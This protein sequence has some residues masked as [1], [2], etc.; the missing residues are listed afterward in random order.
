[1]E[2]NAQILANL[3]FLCLNMRL[4]VNCAKL[5]LQ[6]YHFKYHLFYPM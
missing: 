3:H 1:M 6:A 2:K 4:G 5:T